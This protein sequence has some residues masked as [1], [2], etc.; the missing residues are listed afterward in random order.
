MMAT[1]QQLGHSRPA[2]GQAITGSEDQHLARHRPRHAA[3]HHGG[4]VHAAVHAAAHAPWGGHGGALG[5]PVPPS[6]GSGVHGIPIKALHSQGS[7]WRAPN[8]S[9][10]ASWPGPFQSSA[11]G[12]KWHVCAKA[13]TCPHAVTRLH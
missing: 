4:G 2:S 11:K 13:P 10:Q 7:S 5:S 3:P 6:G 1:S 9:L 12:T 8:A